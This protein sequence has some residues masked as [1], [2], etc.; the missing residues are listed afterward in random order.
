MPVSENHMVRCVSKG[1]D[2][3]VTAIGGTNSDGKS[4]K[5]SADQAVDGIKSGKYK[6]YITID[7]KGTWIVLDQQQGKDVLKSEGD[8]SILT[9]LPECA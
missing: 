1:S 6:F 5:M 4:W 8:S 2:G 9:S 7:G 3:R